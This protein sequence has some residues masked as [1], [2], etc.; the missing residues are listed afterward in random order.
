MILCVYL[1]ENSTELGGT[2]KSVKIGKSAFRRR[3]YT[4]GKTQKLVGFGDEG[5]G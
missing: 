3:K 5:S 1:E 4:S 2:G